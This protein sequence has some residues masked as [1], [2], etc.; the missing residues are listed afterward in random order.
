MRQ[1]L[2]RA[3]TP[4]FESQ[5][6]ITTPAR[7]I[8]IGPSMPVRG[9]ACP[10]RRQRTGKDSDRRQIRLQASSGRFDS[11]TKESH[12][13][14]PCT[15]GLAIPARRQDHSIIARTEEAFSGLFRISEP[16]FLDRCPSF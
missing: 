3:R 11:I 12:W 10:V 5:V 4:S 15:L 6:A 9:I 16:E 1:I 2:G 13:G 8:V 7:K 14:W